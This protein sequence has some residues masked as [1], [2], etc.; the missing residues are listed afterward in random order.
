MDNI[1]QII[2]TIATVAGSAG[3]WKFFESRLKVRAQEKKDAL[4]NND[5]VQYRDDLKNRVRNLEALLA[6]SSDEKDEL[7]NQVLQLTQEVSAL[8]VKVEYLEKEND[9]LKNK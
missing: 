1:T 4:E 2:I 3:I 5:G 7:R 9:R 8:R 6:Q